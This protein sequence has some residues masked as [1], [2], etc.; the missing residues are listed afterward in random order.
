MTGPVSIAYK[1]PTVHTRVLTRKDL[2]ASGVEFPE[3]AT[4]NKMVWAAGEDRRPL[5]LDDPPAALV[6]FFENE[7]HF[8]VKQDGE[9]TSK[10]HDDAGKVLA[11]GSSAVTGEGGSAVLHE[12]VGDDQIGTP[13]SPGGTGGD[14]TSTDATSTTA[15]T[16]STKGRSR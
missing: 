13:A 16:G 10:A 15:G 7:P 3:G 5:I 11:D 12:A 14:S 2:E 8:E 9:V 4:V 6:E 1:G